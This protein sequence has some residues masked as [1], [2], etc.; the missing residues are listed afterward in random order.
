VENLTNKHPIW[1]P[2]IMYFFQKQLSKHLHPPL[3]ML[4]QY[5]RNAYDALLNHFSE[6]TPSSASMQIPTRIKVALK[7]FDVCSKNRHYHVH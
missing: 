1:T 4:H 5:F 3:L 7:L 2:T 6:T